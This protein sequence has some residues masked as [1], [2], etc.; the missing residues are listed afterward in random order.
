MTRFLHT[1]DWQLGMT[2]HYLSAREDD[3]PQARFTADRIQAVRRLG[4]LARA[5][6]CRFVVVAGD[7]FETQNVSASVRARACEALASIGLPTF[8]LPGN[9]DSLEPGCIWDQPDL[10]AQLPATVT[11]LRDTTPVEVAGVEVVGVPLTSRHAVG[12][13][14]AP[15]LDAL[16]S[17]GIPRVAVAH[18]QLEGATGNQGPGLF[19]RAP[20]ERALA[21]GALSYLALGDRH[22]ASPADDPHDPVRHSGTHETTSFAEPGRGTAVV[23][24]LDAD[25]ITATEHVVGTWLHTRISRDLTTDSDLDAL[26]ATLAGLDHRDRTI[27]RYDF[28][29]VLTL[30]QKARLDAM[31]AHHGAA[32]ASLEASAGR[33]DLDVVPDDAD[34]AGLDLPAWAAEGVAELTEA[35]RQG[36]EEAGTALVLLLRLARATGDHDATRRAR[37]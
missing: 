4:E 36:D 33:H 37:S 27:V 3:D 25:G 8:L 5:E 31:L 28:H 10:V 24:D 17:D 34:L 32:L 14:L 6:G 30:A 15:V 19:A 1:S 7:V 22:I 13:V 11:V 35:A 29:G 12:D 23:V 9:H 18:G 21:R 16:P 2:R 20:I 26:D